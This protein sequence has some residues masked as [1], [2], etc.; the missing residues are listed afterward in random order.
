MD[1]AG[2]LALGYSVSSSSLSRHQFVIAGRVPTD[3][4]GTL[5]AEVNIVSGTGSQSGN[6]LSRWGDYSAMQVDPVDDCTFW[7]TRGVYEDRL[8]ALTGTPASRISSFPAAERR[9]RLIFPLA[10]RPASLTVTQGSNGTSTITITSLNGFNSATTLSASG[11]PSG[12]TAAFS[13]EPRDSSSEWQR[14]IHLDSDRVVDGDHRH[15]H[16]DHHRHIG[17]YY[18]YRN[19]CS[20][21]ERDCP[22]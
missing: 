16:G 9:R 12:V 14:H 20:D 8:A 22:A 17:L 1:Q 4:A 13:H 11:L 10:P 21:G 15:S 19:D 3:P 18:S 7:F 2:D 5:E 6:S